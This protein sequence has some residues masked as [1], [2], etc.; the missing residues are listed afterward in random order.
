MNQQELT[1]EILQRLD[2]LAQ[3][4]GTTVEHLWPLLVKEQSVMGWAGLVALALL[5]LF[6]VASLLGGLIADKEVPTCLGGFSLFLFCA[7][8]LPMLCVEVL[9]RIVAPEAAALRSLIQ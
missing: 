7:I 5:F 8:G 1:Q 9:P 4:L 2:A 3:K 6:G